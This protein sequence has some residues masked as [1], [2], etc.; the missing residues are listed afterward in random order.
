MP[1]LTTSMNAL[2]LALRQFRDGLV[3]R[4]PQAV[5]VVGR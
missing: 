1:M 5:S 2:W 4:Q 3:S